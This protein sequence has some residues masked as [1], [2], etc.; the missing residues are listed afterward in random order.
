M[1]KIEMR[2]QVVIYNVN[3]G[4]G[5][6]SSGVEYAQAYRYS[7]LKSL[8]IEQKY[9]FLDFTS[10]STVYQLCDNIGVDSKDVLWFYDILLGRKT[11][12]SSLT[13]TDLKRVFSD[14]DLERVG[15]N[16][17]FKL[18]E[19]TYVLAYEDALNKGF[20]NRLEYVHNYCLVRKDYY[21]EK[22]LYC[23]EYYTPVNNVAK[24][25]KRVFYQDS[26][27]VL[28]EYEGGSLG[29]YF[30]YEGIYYPSK[31][32]L[33]Q[34]VLERLKLTS[35]DTVILDRS[36]GTAKAVFELKNRVPF[37]LVVV[38]HAEHFVHE[39]VTKQGILWNNYYDYQFRNKHLVDAFICSTELQSS[40]LREQLRLGSDRVKT[41]PVGF[42]NTLKGS[43][44][45]DRHKFITVS[46]LSDEKH[47]DTMVQAFAK[48]CKQHDLYLDIY[49]E[50]GE[51]SKLES[52]I[53]ELGVSD[54]IKL[55]GHQNLKDVYENYSTY[56][57][58]SSGEGFG[59]SLLEAVGSG[60]YV[61]GFKANYGTPT[62]TKEGITGFLLDLPQDNNYL[63]EDIL[64]SFADIIERSYLA[65]L[66][67]AKVY[68]LASAYLKD[69]VVKYWK[70][71]LND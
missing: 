68:E 38:V 5:L 60:L 54:Y 40:I 41:I 7:A 55:K 1:I 33:F 14:Y 29:S 34:V 63:S 57:C 16:L 61:S 56:L 70:E 28:E 20:Y 15:S 50:G 31:E 66:D 45:R 2:F 47:L 32:N 12:P 58:A 13:E 49:G 25:Y 26:L 21:S 44:E 18:L 43:L 19:Q 9:I 3:L 52:L 59:L 17:K 11:H 10:V 46:R 36:T 62:F 39:G 22:S 8:G 64:V 53:I 4:I 48:V 24:L 69:S 30:L 71:F 35:E 51:R 65:D 6:A 23:S 27:S 67:R 42:L 37:K